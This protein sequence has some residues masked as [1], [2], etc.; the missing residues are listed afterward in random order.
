MTTAAHNAQRSSSVRRYIA[1]VTS[2][3]IAVLIIVT[4]LRFAPTTNTSPMHPNSVSPGGAGAVAAI[5]EDH[6][7]PV[8]FVTTV[9]EA[10]DPHATVLV[11][12][13]AGLLSISDQAKL[14]N[15]ASHVVVVASESWAPAPRRSVEAKGDITGQCESPRTDVPISPV[16]AVFETPGCYPVDGDAFLVDEGNVRFI[17]GI[18][19][20][21][22]AYLKDSG[23]AALALKSLGQDDSVIWLIPEPRGDTST[24]IATIPAPLSAGL[25]ALVGV[26]FWLA[27]VRRPLGDPVPERLPAEVPATET[28][29]G[30]AL[31]YERSKCSEHAARSLRAGIISR[32]A[33]SLGLSDTDSPALVV[34]RIADT[35]QRPTAQIHELLYGPLPSTT[36]EL[37]QLH[38]DLSELSKELRN[39]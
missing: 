37:V 15:G 3:I 30:R 34:Q 1:I 36:N 10:L 23:N 24:P 2:L 7:K 27:V 5:L 8:R 4:I 14:K 19:I 13:N 16:S 32:H 11:W 35:C 26:A 20:F 38:H 22:N 9:D 31:L 17:A 6:G 25:V 21:T 12:D 29:R 18:E 28:F 39:A 33:S